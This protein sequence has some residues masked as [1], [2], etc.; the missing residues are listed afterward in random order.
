MLL[1]DVPFANKAKAV[2]LYQTEEKA[3]F[4]GS[5][6]VLLISVGQDVHEGSKLSAV[7]DLINR[8]FKSCD[9]AACDVLQR[10]SMQITD[11][12]PIEDIY[13]KS[14]I[15]GS[16]W[17]ARNNKHLQQ[18]I[19]PNKIFSWE[20]YLLRPDFL[21]YRENII[22]AYNEDS[23]FKQA[24]NETIDDFINRYERRFISFDKERAFN[25]CFNYL[26]EE[27]AILMLMWQK[28]GYNYIIYP[29]NMPKTLSA[30]RDKFVAPVNPHLLKWVTV[31]VRNKIRKVA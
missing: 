25:C 22:I 9:I 11:L 7:I 23:L 6:A 1:Q 30:T 3:N 28:S 27:C 10:H 29:G 12:S 18:L 26:V 15:A 8:N 5:H 14:S 13:K 4:P 2:F 16:D 21:I 17:I 20:E 31:Y 24:M 19:I